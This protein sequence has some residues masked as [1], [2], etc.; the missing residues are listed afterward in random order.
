MA[1]DR[2]RMFVDAHIDDISVV[3]YLGVK[4]WMCTRRLPIHNLSV[5]LFTISLL[6]ATTIAC[7]TNS[8]I[9]VTHSTI[10]GG[11]SLENCVPQFKLLAEIPGTCSNHR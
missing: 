1:P 8:I 2:F 10:C 7:H 6:Q 5:P 9:K 4:P 11:S 3:H